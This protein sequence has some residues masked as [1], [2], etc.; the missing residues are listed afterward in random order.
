MNFQ[1]AV[2]TLSIEF[3]NTLWIDERV[4]SFLNLKTLLL[5]PELVR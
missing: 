5:Q 3:L 1:P 2:T 4:N